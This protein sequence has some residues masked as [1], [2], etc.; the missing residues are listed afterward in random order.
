MI[1]FNLL[2]DVKLEFVKAQRTKRTVITSAF[3]ATAASL[4]LFLLLFL[5]V[6]V[7]QK[8]SLSNL[9]SD[10][11]KYSTE[12]K[13]TPD[14][15]KILT[16]QNQLSVLDGMHDDKSVSSRAFGFMQ[17]VTPA[18]IT[19]SELATDYALG[20]ISITGQAASLDKVNTFTD[21]LKFATFTTAQAQKQKA[22][23][24]VVLSQFSRNEKDATY[25]ITTGFAPALFSNADNISLEIPKT[26]TTRSVVE[27]PTDIFKMP[28]VTPKTQGTR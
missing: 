11:K 3:I 12:L 28:A 15:N 27:Q 23:P 21:T 7:I 14:L 20:T 19:I 26:V 16:I 13:Q 4:G 17:Q 5:T 1:Q 2:P 10:I 24:N 25:T 18:D 8:T 6:H 9:N 22:F